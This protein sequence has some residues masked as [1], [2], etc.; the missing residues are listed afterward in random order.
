MNQCARWAFRV[1]VLCLAGLGACADPPATSTDLNPTTEASGG[2]SAGRGVVPCAPEFM[3]FRPGGEGIGLVAMGEAMRV[4]ARVIA[5]SPPMPE[6]YDNDWTV[7]FMDVQGRPLNDLEIVGACAYM[8]AVG[9][10]HFDPPGH[11]TQQADP[12][13]FTLEAINLSMRGAWELQLAISSPTIGGTP[14]FD[15]RCAGKSSPLGADR[16]VLRACITDG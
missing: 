5:A 13:T 10:R 1:A 16:I 15:T 8:P 3:N 9:H 2:A 7:R 14:T 12:S 11:I 6:R 4:Q